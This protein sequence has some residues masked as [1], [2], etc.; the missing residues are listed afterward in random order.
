LASPLGERNLE[1]IQRFVADEVALLVRGAWSGDDEQAAVRPL[2]PDRLLSL[3]KSQELE[4]S[5]VS[6]SLAHYFLSSVRAALRML[7]MA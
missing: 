7:R 3:M 1:L 4:G 6:G 2:D 5:T